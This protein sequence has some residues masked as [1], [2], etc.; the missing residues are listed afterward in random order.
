MS[1]EL[2]G[3]VWWTFVALWG[4]IRLPHVLHARTEPIRATQRDL[5]DRIARSAAVFGLGI[6]PGAYTIIHF[7]MAADRA[8][9][10]VLT[11]A[12]ACL[13]A[14]SLWLFYRTHHDLG[15]RFSASLEIRREHTLVTTGIYARVRHP[16]YTAF[17]LWAVGQALVLPNW[18]VA[19][20]G[21]L[22][23][24]YLFAARVGREERLMER[25]FGDQYRTYMAR[26]A[27]LLP[28][29]Y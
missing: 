17:W 26:T 28:G 4:V 19:L 29:I 18:F 6:I 14:V 12:G 11:W 23:M 27:R 21:V 10:P 2:A 15:R 8:H 1:R 24:A 16:M 5:R 9:L 13:L 22:G 3:Y 20:A 7:P 25:E